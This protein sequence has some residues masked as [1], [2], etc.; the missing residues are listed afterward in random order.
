MH[1]IRLSSDGTE[2]V[3]E[4]L[5]SHPNEI[6]DLSSC[7]FDQRIFSTVYSTGNLF[8]FLLLFFSLFIN[9]FAHFVYEWCLNGID[10]FALL[11]CE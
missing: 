9:F 4:G 8:S 6:W 2:L 10:A 7:P 5:F 3:C 11:C 1:L